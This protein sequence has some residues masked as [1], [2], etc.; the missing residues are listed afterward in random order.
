[1]FFQLRKLREAAGSGVGAKCGLFS[2]RGNHT[3]LYIDEK[4][5]CAERFGHVFLF[6]RKT[7]NARKIQM[8]PE[9]HIALFFSKN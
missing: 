4:N 6:L 2:D 7:P 9:L 8:E 1:M 3:V 5:L